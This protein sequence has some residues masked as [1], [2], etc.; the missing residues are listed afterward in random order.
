M[1][2][3]AK[4]GYVDGPRGDGDDSVPFML[5]HAEH[6]LTEDQVRLLTPDLVMKL[7]EETR[8]GEEPFSWRVSPDAIREAEE[9]Q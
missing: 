4:G 6:S 3:F 2:G 7:T 9:R 1:S 8:G 5:Y